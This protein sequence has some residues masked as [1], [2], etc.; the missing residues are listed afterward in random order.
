MAYPDLQNSSINEA[1]PWSAPGGIVYGKDGQV[2]RRMV[3]TVALRSGDVV[4]LDPTNGPYNVTKTAVGDSPLRYGVAVGS[5]VGVQVAAIAADVW[6]CI[7]GVAITAGA[8]GIVIGSTVASSAV[9]AGLA[10]PA[11]ASTTGAVGRALMGLPATVSL[12]ASIVSQSYVDI[13]FTPA[14]LTSADNPIAFTPNASLPANAIIGGLWMD[15]SVSVA[16]R[17]ANP[18]TVPVGSFSSIPGILYT[19]RSGVGV[20]GAGLGIAI[21]SATA[22]SAGFQLYLDKR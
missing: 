21:T 11:G 16:I 12:A 5:Q 19:A 15:G 3:A 4:L 9:A 20:P 18:A 7:E 6:I 17:I 1:G 2:L 8:T 22:A 13:K 14:G 10:G